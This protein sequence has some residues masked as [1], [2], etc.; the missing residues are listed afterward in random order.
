MQVELLDQDD[1]DGQLSAMQPCDLLPMVSLHIA[2]LGRSSECLAIHNVGNVEEKQRHKFA[3]R[4]DRPSHKP[5][6]EKLQ[7]VVVYC[8][9]EH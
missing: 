3:V 4:R 6:D 1:H 2:A 9:L 5:L 8:D 7:D